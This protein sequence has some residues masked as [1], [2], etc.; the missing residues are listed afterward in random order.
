MVY[1]GLW[2]ILIVF[3]LMFFRGANSNCITEEREINTET[4]K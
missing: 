2:L 1:I 4:K 3:I